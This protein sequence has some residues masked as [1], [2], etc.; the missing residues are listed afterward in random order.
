MINAAHY[1][2][3]F[4]RFYETKESIWLL[5]CYPIAY[6]RLITR[7][8]WPKVAHLILISSDFRRRVNFDSS[9]M[10][11][12]TWFIFQVFLFP[13][14]RFLNIQVNIKT[15][16]RRGGMNIDLGVI[17]WITIKEV[18]LTMQQVFFWQYFLKIL[19]YICLYKIKWLP[20]AG[21][22]SIDPVTLWTILVEATPTGQS[23]SLVEFT[24]VS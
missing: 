17:I 20:P 14:E 19:L 15:S 2:C 22:I 9:A 4:K 18:H 24:R 21:L 11:V 10:I 16:G 1:K 7:S 3:N 13:T 8:H 12:Q 23:V 5:S 6:L